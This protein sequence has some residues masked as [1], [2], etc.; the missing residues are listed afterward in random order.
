MNKEKLER[1]SQESTPLDFNQRHRGNALISYQ[2]DKKAPAWLQNTGLHFLFRFNSGHN[3][4]L[5]EG[6]FG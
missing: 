5:Y 1:I 2:T 3:F 6:G 4:K